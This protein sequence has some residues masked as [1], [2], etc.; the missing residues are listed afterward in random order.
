MNANDISVE[1]GTN[2]ETGKSTAIVTDRNANR[3]WSGEGATHSE[4]A[5]D[6]TRKFI[7][8]RR[9]REYLGREG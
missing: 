3:A 7:G 8:D 4:A 2:V 6:A 9:S 1:L 5:T